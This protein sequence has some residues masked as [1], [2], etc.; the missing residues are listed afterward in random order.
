MPTMDSY[1]W[2]NE[3][4]GEHTQY[5]GHPLILACMVMDRYP[6]LEAALEGRPGIVRNPQKKRLADCSKTKSHLADAKA[7]FHRPALVN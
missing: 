2:E 1:R 4:L 6:N 3:V 5:P 7:G